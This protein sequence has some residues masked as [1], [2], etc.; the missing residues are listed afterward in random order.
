MGRFSKI[1]HDIEA[2]KPKDTAVQPTLSKPLPAM[3]KAELEHSSSDTSFLKQP[4]DLADEDLDVFSKIPLSKV[5]SQNPTPQEQ[6]SQSGPAH[7]NLLKTPHIVEDNTETAPFTDKA[8]LETKIKLHARLIEE[9]DLT[10]LDG[11]ETSV[12]KDHVFEIVKD[13]AREERLKMNA[14][15]LRELSK[16]IYDEMTGLGPLEVLLQDE[17][18]TDILINTHKMVYVERRGELELS[19]VQFANED[20]LL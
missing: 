16:G 15:E 20:H 7:N 2:Y 14:S 3:Q 19:P 12:L 13:M 8:W 6:S 4:G 10:S 18:V 9:I 5:Q 11:L 17:T 1:L